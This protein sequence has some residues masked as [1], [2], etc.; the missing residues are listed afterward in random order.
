MHGQVSV[1]GIHG[2]LIAENG[3]KLNF[4]LRLHYD[5]GV[6]RRYSIRVVTIPSQGGF[7]RVVDFVYLDKGEKDSRAA[8]EKDVEEMTGAVDSKCA[9]QSLQNVLGICGESDVVIDGCL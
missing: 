4:T 3:E 2:Q 6:T 9:L 1:F 8:F 7:A 5:F